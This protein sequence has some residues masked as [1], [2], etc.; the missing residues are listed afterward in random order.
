[1][2]LGQVEP[3]TIDLDEIEARLKRPEYAPVA[4][5][6]REI[7]MYSAVDLFATYAGQREGLRG[8]AEGRARSTA[9]ATCGCSIWPAAGS[10]STGPTSSSP[11][12]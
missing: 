3:T 8:L 7:G 5:S 4:Q 12:C 6:L 1:M 10:I 2:L 11:T 9:I